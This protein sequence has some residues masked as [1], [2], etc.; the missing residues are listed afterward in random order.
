[1][2]CPI[3]TIRRATSIHH[4]KPR[5]SG[6]SNNHKNKVMLCKPCHDIVE[7]V[8]NNTGAE[9]SPRV[10]E[11]IRV[12]YSFPVRDIDKDISRSI[13]TTSLYRMRRKYKFAKEKNTR[14]A[15]PDSVAMRCPYCGKWHY[16]NRNGFIICPM[17]RGVI[18]QARETT[19]FFNTLIEKIN[20]V[21]ANI[22]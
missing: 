7:E 8:Y 1:L 16:P 4:I 3:C 10:I 17:L 5:D 13:L 9:L 20:R 15:V 2:K 14:T 18:T 22:E 19:T 11:L 6:G 12:K 21:R